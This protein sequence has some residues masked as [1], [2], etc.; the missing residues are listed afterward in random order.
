METLK[1]FARRT[2]QS[3]REMVSGGESSPA[4]A[5]LTEISSK[6]KTMEAKGEVICQ[7]VIQA[8][9]LMEELG[10]TLKELGEEYKGVPDL[11]KESRELAEDVFIVG[12]KLMET[13]QEHQKG[14][15]DNGFELLRA[16]SKQCAHLREVE[17][18][19][20][21]HQLEYDFFKSKVQDLRSVPQKDFTRL[22]RN[23]QILESWRV[24]LWR[25]SEQSKALCSQLY[26]DGR[27]AIDRSVLT[28]VQVLHS[29]VEIASSGF[30]QTFQSV[31]LPSYPLEPV[32]PP[33]A[34]PAAPAPSS[35]PAVHY[36]ASGG[37]Y[38]PPSAQGYG[39]AGGNTSASGSFNVPSSR[40]SL[41]GAS[42][43]GGAPAPVAP[44]APAASAG[45]LLGP[46]TPLTYASASERTDATG[47]GADYEPPPLD[48]SEGRGD[49]SG[50][51][52]PPTV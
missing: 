9:R 7:K 25:V 43:N 27:R 49:A 29:F 24:E 14:L 41:L 31:R 2:T 8:A 37:S 22:P 4:D 34:L 10:T 23:E 11:P 12:I 36:G 18:T 47:G 33:T 42:G 3:L 5:R 15:K 32:L 35:S 45:S 46:H 13:S 38:A 30:A 26:V 17:E 44:P 39:Y 20:R 52:Q 48:S 21:H 51:Y 28:T 6:V 19:R 40:A 1:G 16:F 50:G